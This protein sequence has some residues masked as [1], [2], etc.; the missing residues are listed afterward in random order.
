[1]LT[2]NWPWFW[3]STRTNRTEGGNPNRRL[4]IGNSGQLY[5]LRTGL[6]KINNGASQAL[7]VVTAFI[8]RDGVGK[9]CT[10]HCLT[11]LRAA[12][13]SSCPRRYLREVYVLG[14][15]H[16][17]VGKVMLVSS[18]FLE[19]QEAPRAIPS[20]P[21]PECFGGT[22]PR[23][24][25]HR[26]VRLCPAGH[27]SPC[28]QLVHLYAVRKRQLDLI[29]AWKK[30]VFLWTSNNELRATSLMH[31]PSKY[32]LSGNARFPPLLLPRSSSSALPPKQ[33]QMATRSH[34]VPRCLRR[35]QQ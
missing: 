19:D 13:P 32:A 23:S 7:V 18:L 35:F 28:P 8:L 11:V 12:T 30:R 21:G 2:R 6:Q 26:L 15:D 20:L 31:S 29:F 4:P 22:W 24:P 9:H 34:A 16:S 33:A 1:M 5:S 17:P 10:W 27:I 14:K 3:R 25:A